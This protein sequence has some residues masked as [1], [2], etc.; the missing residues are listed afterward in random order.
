MMLVESSLQ[1]HDLFQSNVLK[2][3]NYV[4]DAH[5]LNVSRYYI[6]TINFQRYDLPLRVH[7]RRKVPVGRN[8]FGNGFMIT[9]TNIETLSAH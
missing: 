1:L 8:C 3:M 6:D 7:Q 9:V 5:N 2:K 4:I